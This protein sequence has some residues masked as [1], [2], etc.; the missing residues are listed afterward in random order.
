MAKRSRDPSPPEDWPE[1]Y[2]EK[3]SGIDHYRHKLRKRKRIDH[4][5]LFREP[6]LVRPVPPGAYARPKLTDQKEELDRLLGQIRS[7]CDACDKMDQRDVTNKAIAI[8]DAKTF[9][10]EIRT[11]YHRCVIQ[12][13][14]S[15]FYK[16]IKYLLE[17]IDKD[18]Q[19][20][21]DDINFTVFSV[22]HRV[23]EMQAD[24]NY[25]RQTGR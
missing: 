10:K 9:A 23:D 15:R 20:E 12:G 22:R 1:E 7:I 14:E 25:W 5:T 24:V 16:N 18:Q 3:L 2:P 4:H 11:L 19:N 8:L 13:G 6:T 21:W 17:A